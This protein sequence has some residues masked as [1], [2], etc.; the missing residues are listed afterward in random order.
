M[1]LKKR[2][3]PS[4]VFSMASLTDIIFLL[5][6]FFVINSEMPNALKLLL[7]NATGQT[8]ANTTIDV[9]ITHDLDYMVEGDLVMYG[10]LEAAIARAIAATGASEPT[11]VVR[12]DKRVDVGSLVDVLKLGDDLQVEMILATKPERP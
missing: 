8:S 5:L 7:P 10:E 12:S 2:H 9:S 3:K 4:A 6:I 11:V 1:K